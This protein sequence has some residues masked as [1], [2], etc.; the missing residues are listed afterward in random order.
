MRLLTTSEADSSF[1]PRDIIGPD[2]WA[3][4]RVGAD[5]AL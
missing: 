4:A 2:F 5:F 1:L 3:A